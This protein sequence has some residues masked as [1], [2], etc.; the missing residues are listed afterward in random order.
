M[1]V[2]SSALVS[3]PKGTNGVTVCAFVLF[4][5]FGLRHRRNRAG[6]SQVAGTTI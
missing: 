6:D 2:F 5:R 1:W 4:G 3:L